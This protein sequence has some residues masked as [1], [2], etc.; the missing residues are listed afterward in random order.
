MGNCSQ[1]TCNDHDHKKEKR[2]IY[3][4]LQ[5]DSKLEC[6]VIDIFEIS[7]QK[8]I[9]VLPTN[10]ETALLYR[11]TENKDEISLSN[12]ESDEEYTMAGDV[13]LKKNS[14]NYI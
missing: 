8:Y 13:F 1:G 6:D 5:D 9:A 4:T 12:I 10:S 14:H 3:L 2:K 7:P 11:F